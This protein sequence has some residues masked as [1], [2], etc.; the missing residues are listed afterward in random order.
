MHLNTQD[1]YIIAISLALFICLTF[2]LIPIA[3]LTGLLDQPNNRKKHRHATPLIGGITLYCTTLLAV[4]FT[5]LNYLP[6]LSFFLGGG[7]LLIVGIIDDKYDISPRIRLLS[8]AIS[9]YLL[10][11]PGHLT[12]S[13]FGDLFNTGQPILFHLSAPVITIVAVIGYINA[14]NMLDG[15]DGLLGGVSF[16]IL[17]WLALI[18]Y[19]TSQQDTYTMLLILL[20]ALAGFLLFNY[21][22][23]WYKQAKIFMGDAGSTLIGF[24][25]AWF[26]IKLN[27]I[28]PPAENIYPVTFL[29]IL[30]YP[31][32]DIASTIIRRL[33]EKK[34]PFRPDRGHLH[35]LLE[36]MG[37]KHTASTW[38]LYILTFVCGAYGLLGS[39]YGLKESTLF[40]SFIGSLL[41]YITFV[42]VIYR[43][44]QLDS[45]P[46]QTK[47]WQ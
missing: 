25:C 34:S 8:Q 12:L 38:V 30:A 2:C 21:R 46:V 22:W 43:Q 47:E 14:M 13:S 40:Y 41:V 17:C 29:W 27:Q 11:F 10:I 1:T 28:T 5:P 44:K 9:G 6:Y 19:A 32:F 15:Q 31:I 42:I 37:L 33:I 18:A 23:P 45:S 20:S 16:I 7:L 3:K 24:T 36:Q 39:R 4:L 35:H 26:A